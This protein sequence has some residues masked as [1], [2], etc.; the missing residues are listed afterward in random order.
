MGRPGG[1]IVNIG[2][3]MSVAANPTASAYCGSKAAMLMTTRTAA[4]GRHGV[5][6]NAPPPG[7]VDTPMLMGALGPGDAAA[8][9]LDALARHGALGRLAA[10]EDIAKAALFLAD[11]ANG[12]VS[13]VH[14]PVDGGSMT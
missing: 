2:S 8:A 14:L 3:S 6:M 11:Q 1:A 13:G 9:Y 12:A 7:A 4:A 10:A 5:R